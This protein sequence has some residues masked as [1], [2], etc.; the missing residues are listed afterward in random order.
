MALI[1]EPEKINIK[2]S[3][4]FQIRNQQSTKRR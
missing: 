2:F 4:R 1:L 3:K